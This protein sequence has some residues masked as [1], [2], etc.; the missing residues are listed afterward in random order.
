MDGYPFVTSKQIRDVR[1]KAVGKSKRTSFKPNQSK[2]INDIGV[3][4]EF[5]FFDPMH[6]TEHHW[7]CQISRPIA[8]SSNSISFDGRTPVISLT[9]R[10]GWTHAAISRLVSCGYNAES[11]TNIICAVPSSIKDA[12][13]QALISVKGI[14]KNLLACSDE[15]A[16]PCYVKVKETIRLLSSGDRSLWLNDTKR[17]IRILAFDPVTQCPTWLFINPSTQCAF[18]M[19]TEE[20]L[21]RSAAHDLPLGMPDLDFLC[22]FL[23]VVIS[24]V[25][26]PRL[27]RARYI[28]SMAGPGR[29]YV[30]LLWCSVGVLGPDRRMVE[31][32]PCAARIII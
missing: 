18:G 24:G 13:N 7:S 31:A 26:V 19:H 1:R 22:L 11:I 12:I 4:S 30:L 28:R 16:L 23:A 8:F 14:S 2:K 27:V 15:M 9:L 17:S 5:E 3:S 10:E 29:G 25:A 32:S 21:S 6:G 20:Y